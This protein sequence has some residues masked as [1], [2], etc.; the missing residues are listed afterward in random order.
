MHWKVGHFAAIVGRSNGLIHIKDPVMPKNDLWITAN[1]LD[2][3]ATGYMLVPGSE[4][5]SAGWQTVSAKKASEIWGKGPTNN[6]RP[7]WPPHAVPAK[8]CNCPQNKFSGLSKYNIGEAAVSLSISDTPVGYSPPIGPSPQTTINYDQREDSQPANFNFFNV[9]QKWKMNWL[10]YVVDDPANPGANVGRF[11]S[12]GGKFYYTGYNS[13]THQFAAQD[14]DGSILT[15]TAQTPVSYTRTLQD[16][17]TEIYSQS[18]GSTSFPRN[19]FRT[20]LIDPQGKAL[21]FAYDSLDRLTIITD[22]TGRQTT[23]AY[24]NG[25]Y[26]LQVTKITDPFGRSA[27]LVY[28]GSGRLSSITDVI[29]LTSS[30]GYD[31]NSLVS[32]LTTPY[33][34]TSF[35][36]TTPGTSGP[37]RFVQVTDPRGNREREEWLEPAPIPNADPASVVPSGMPLA[38]LNDYLQYRNSFHW[39]A[40]QYVA[41][42]CTPTGG[43]DYAKARITHFLHDGNSTTTRSPI[44]ESVKQPLENRVFYQYFGQTISAFSSNTFDKPTTIAR[45]LD[46]GST[47][48]SSFTYDNTGLYNL[49]QSVDPLGRTTKYTYVN[50]VDVQTV[51]QKVAGGA[52]ANIAQYTYN[53]QH[54]PLTSIDASGQTSIFTYNA[55]GQVLTAKDP[56]LNVTQYQ[57][58]PNGQLTAIINAN[59]LTARALTYDAADRVATMTDSEGWTV[60]YSYDAADRVSVKTY[61]DGTTERY[62]YD[63][64]DL[65]SYQDRLKRTWTYLYD[66]NSNLIKVTDPLKNF[67]QFAYSPNDRLI[68]L[69]DAKLNVTTW[70][71]DL[72]GRPTSKKYANNSLVTFAYETTTSRLKSRTDALNQVKTFAYAKDDQIS[73]L[74]YTG[75]VNSTPNVSFTYD[76]YFGYVTGMTDGTGTTTYAYGAVGSLGALQLSLETGPIAAAATSYAYDGVGRMKTRTVGGSAAETFGFDAIGRT[77]SHGSDLG[78]FTL[79]Y[80]GQ[81]AQ[82]TQQ[83]LTSTTLKTTLTYLP[84]ASDRRLSAINNTGLTAAKFL[85]LA[86]TS[87]AGGQVTDVTET[88]DLATVYPVASTQS[89]TVNNLNQITALSGTAYT[90]DLN[91]NLTGDGIRT[92][93]WDAENRL[94]RI[95]YATPAGKLTTMSYDG[96]SRRTSI[97]SKPTT[98]GAPVVV[99]YVWCGTMLCQARSAANAVTRRYLVEG[100]YVPGTTPVKYYYATDQVGSVRRVFAS[101][102]TTPAYAYD[103]YGNPLQTTAQVTDKGYAGMFT[104]KDSG[105]NLTLYRGYN[106]N[107]GRWLSRDPVGEEADPDRTLYSYVGGDAI[108]LNDP[109]GLQTPGPVS[110]RA[111]QRQCSLAT[112]IKLQIDVEWMCFFN[113]IATC[114]GAM[115]C[116][117]LQSQVDKRVKCMEARQRVNSICYAGGDAG[118]RQAVKQM[119]EGIMNCQRIMMRKNCNCPFNP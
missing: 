24:G 51:Q 96:L 102:G 17:S 57:Y 114:S 20:K 5:V 3:E 44:I 19:I 6:T 110:P 10:S 81:T 115:S 106:P 68:T 83:A 2:A 119:F 118:H 97:S 84:N 93:G 46:D 100:E 16:G 65:A 80:L 116:P 34:T 66:A 36:Y 7:G 60:S 47:Q 69:T 27:N 64:L 14:D 48:L 95:G 77:T 50:G 90:Y 111:G 23:L 21:T 89:A 22:A 13:T 38:I 70:A 29:G 4:P 101:N 87:N 42:G 12:G 113:G 45:V 78:A 32:S 15:F 1:A 74:T 91:G 53:A 61:P 25:L 62:T 11:M 41:A 59:N 39:D 40:D 67:T 112:Q 88:S 108:N 31:A 56:L 82:V 72:Q 26:P 117:E 73:T 55:A 107:T 94:V 37:P 33:G 104:N 9:G 63:K 18:N 98:A 76:P 86:L 103:P 28:D 49:T 58:N 109:L 99:N 30:F 52:F 54:R 43:C 35:S 85:N 71:Y 105:L 75:A 8:P 92:Y 79:S